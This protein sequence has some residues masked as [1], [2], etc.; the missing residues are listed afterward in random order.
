VNLLFFPDLEVNVQRETAPFSIQEF[1]HVG[2]NI[3]GRYK[4]YLKAGSRHFKTVL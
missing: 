2:K 4:A 3:F 1:Y